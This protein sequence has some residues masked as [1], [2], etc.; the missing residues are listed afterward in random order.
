MGH[1]GLEHQETSWDSNVEHL[2]PE[3]MSRSWSLLSEHISSTCFLLAVIKRRGVVKLIL[4]RVSKG[5]KGYSWSFI[6]FSC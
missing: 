3:G 1:H 2:R 6:D 5:G 4:R